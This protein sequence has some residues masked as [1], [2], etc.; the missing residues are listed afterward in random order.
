MKIII[1]SFWP[2][3]AC[4]IISSILFFLPGSALPESDWFGKIEL[5]KIVHVAL[6][7]IM[8]V[9]WCIP[10]FYKPSLSTHLPKL[11][12]LIPFIFFG[13]SIL[14]EFI[15]LF[16]IPGRSFDLMDILADALG[17]LIGFL[18][19]KQYQR[20]LTDVK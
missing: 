15:Q 14:V 1:R 18:F 16:F 13:Y 20:F 2:A 9:L 12:I 3:I 6:F 8:V 19:V 10:V 17:C 4:L 11:L 7:A 5:D